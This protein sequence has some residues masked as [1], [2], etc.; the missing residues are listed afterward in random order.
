MRRHLQPAAVLFLTAAEV[1][2]QIPAP[3]IPLHKKQTE[4]LS[5]LWRYT[6]PEPKGDGNALIWD[7]RFKS[8][9]QQHLTAPQTFWGKGKS[10][11]DPALEFLGHPRSLIPQDNRHIIATPYFQTFC[12][13]RWLHS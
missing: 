13:T 7:T 12:H 6:K 10:L 11:P 9:L 1:H 8:L 4:D 5:W 2:A 3:Q